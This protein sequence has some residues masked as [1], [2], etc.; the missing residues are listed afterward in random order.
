MLLEIVVENGTQAVGQEDE[1][2]DEDEA[3]DAD[4]DD[5]DDDSESESENDDDDEVEIGGERGHAPSN[6][7]DDDRQSKSLVR[8]WIEEDDDVS[9][10]RTGARRAVISTTAC[11]STSP[12]QPIRFRRV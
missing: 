4:D 2:D 1:E 9:D 7:G 10:I 8:S 11:F 3:G 5:E 6:S 12:S